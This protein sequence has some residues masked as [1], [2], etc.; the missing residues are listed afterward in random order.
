MY[1]CIITLSEYCINFGTFRYN[2]PN[3]FELIKYRFK[4][5]I[6]M[7]FRPDDFIINFNCFLICI[8]TIDVLYE[9][10]SF[11]SFINSPLL[12]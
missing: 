6:V 4:N 10:V 1:R 2:V 8:I 12:V 9:A 3:Y 5:S 11:I 7:D